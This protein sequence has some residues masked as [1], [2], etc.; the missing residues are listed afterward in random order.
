M[1]PFDFGGCDVI[2]NFANVSCML[3]IPLWMLPRRGPASDVAIELA[4]L[5]LSRSNDV[6]RR[7][8]ALRAYARNE[9]PIPSWN[10]SRSEEEDEKALEG[11][12]ISS[13]VL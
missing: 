9:L 4:F 13:I 1:A 11:R 8:N 6:L 5:R 7:C 3:E 2:E 10:P 12:F